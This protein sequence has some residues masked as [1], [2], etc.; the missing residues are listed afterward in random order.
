MWKLKTLSQLDGL[1]P[2]GV[3]LR[4]EEIARHQQAA[5]IIAQAHQRADA[6]LADARQ[7]AGAE[8]AESRSQLE[9]QFWQQADS[10]FSDWQQQ[11]DRDEVQMVGLAGNVLNE[12]LQQVL[13]E[14]NDA[15]R[16]DALLRQLLRHHPRQQQ[17]TLFCAS[18]QETALAAWL[19]DQPHLVWSL[20]ADPALAGDSLR[21]TTARGELLIDWATLRRSLL[22]PS[23]DTACA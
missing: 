7:Q 11:R 2:E 17:A 8:L 5:D 9:D 20:C 6:I 14:V 23:S 19:A 22:P 21:L 18:S 10:L 16:F 1:T 15:R 12:A 3:V 4:R 13:D